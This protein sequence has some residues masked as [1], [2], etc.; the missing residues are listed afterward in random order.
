[1]RRSKQ[2]EELYTAAQKYFL[3]CDK[4]VVSEHTFQR[5]ARFVVWDIQHQ[6]DAEKTFYYLQDAYQYMLTLYKD[7]KASNT[8]LK[9]VLDK[10]RKK[11]LS[12]A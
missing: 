4:T 11:P 9:F 8:L 7:R 5:Y 3:L 10:R 12:F 2:E 6:C 1:M